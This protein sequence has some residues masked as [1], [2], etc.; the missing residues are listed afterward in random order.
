SLVILRD[1]PADAIA[2]AGGARLDDGAVVAWWRERGATFYAISLEGR[3][4]S[5]VRQTSYDVLLQYDAFDPLERQPGPPSFLAADEASELGIV[6]F[7]TQPLEEYAAA[8]LAAGA[9]IFTYVGNHAYIVR[10]DPAAR[11][12]LG[13]LPFV[14]WVGPF[15]PAYKLEAGLLAQL[16]DADAWRSSG[17]YVIQTAQRGLADQDAVAAE[18][19]ALGGQVLRQTPHGYW[20]E[21]ELTLDQVL[22]LSRRDEVL[23]IEPAL[24]ATNYMNNVRIVG[25]ANYVEQVAG[26]TGQGVRG[27]VMDT[28]LYE[29]HID[30]QVIPPIFHGNRGGNSS[31]GTSVYGIVFGTGTGNPQGRGMLPMGQGIF[32]DFGFLGDRY[33]H[34]AELN[35]P[36]YQAVFQTNS[37]GYCCATQYNTR[38]AEMDLITF[39]LD[40]V[41]LQAQANNGNQSSDQHAWAKNIVSVGG[42]RHYDTLTLDDDAWNGAGSIG[43]AADGRIKP[44][45]SYFYD[46]IYTTSNSGGY[47]SG[48]GG[49]SAATPMTAGH[50]GLFFQMWSQG[51]FGNPVD[52]NGTVFSNRPRMS[53][54]KAMMIN[55]ARPYPFNGVNHDLRRFTQGWGL[56]NVQRLYDLRDSMF[57][58]NETDVLTNLASTTYVLTVAPGTPELRATLVY[59]DLPGV[60]NSSR[61]RI[62]D[63]SLKVVAPDGTLY[64]GNNGLTAGNV[65]TPG[66]SRNSIDTVENVWVLNPA[67]GAWSITISAD[68][69]V[70]DAHVET[71]QLDADYALVVSGVVPP[72]PA[73]LDGDGCV[74]Q[75]DLGILLAA[76]GACPGDANYNQAAGELAGGPCVGQED[77][78]VLLANFGQGCP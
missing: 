46:S 35:Q 30:F 37:W 4:L 6:Q 68:E 65:S 31:H 13:A 7:H 27:E 29:A 16:G 57:I 47:T 67:P 59:T 70:Q 72:T 61:H 66:G 33:V 12:A 9:Q 1:A 77:L 48:F 53:T 58:V 69:I 25:G 2:D 26:F 23:Y 11:Q 75:G 43:P 56:A 34:T 28:N 44:D 78:G 60:P 73:D 50:F 20:V 40:I 3:S 42:I 76:F 74:G 15:H 17:P 14:R 55:S 49:T 36:P 18:I 22:R 8:L 64:W 24:P 10:A 39:D 38:S 51:L 32:A 63:L 62:N 5:T 52:P 41:I 54:S 71:P 19:A 21:A 45:L